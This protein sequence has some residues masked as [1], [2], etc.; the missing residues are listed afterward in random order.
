MQ[1]HERD[2]W[3]KGHVVTAHIVSS[4]THFRGS[5]FEPR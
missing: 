5:M 4:H 3:N 1:N 2:E